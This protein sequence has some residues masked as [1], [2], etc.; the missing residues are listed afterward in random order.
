M[1]D[2]VCYI[3]EHRVRHLDLPRGQD[4]NVNLLNFVGELTRE[5]RSLQLMPHM[6]GLT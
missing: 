5:A 6:K 2:Q 3:Y 4:E 1:D